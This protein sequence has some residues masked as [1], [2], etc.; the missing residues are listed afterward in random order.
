MSKLWLRYALSA[1]AALTIAGFAGG[2]SGPAAVQQDSQ[3]GL[4][5]PEDSQWGAATAKG[6]TASL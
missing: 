3:W 5:L 6:E 4:V 2:N 1:L